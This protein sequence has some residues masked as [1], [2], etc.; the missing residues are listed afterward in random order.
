M[1]LLLIYAVLTIGT[2]GE[3]FVMGNSLLTFAERSYFI[4]IG[5]FTVWIC[6]RV[7]ARRGL[8]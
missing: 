8:V 3:C 7:G 1:P 2:A 4:G 5:I 6:E